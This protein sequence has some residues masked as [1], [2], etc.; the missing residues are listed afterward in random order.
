MQAAQGPSELEGDEEAVGPRRRSAGEVEE[1]V[2]GAVG[3]VFGDDD[4]A[5]AGDAEEVDGA[6]I[7]RDGGEDESFV[8]ER[9]V[10]SKVL[11]GQGLLLH[12][13]VAAVV[14]DASVYAAVAAFSDQPPRREA[15]CSIFN[16]LHLKYM[17]FSSFSC[18]SLL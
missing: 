18:S 4:C 3:H 5:V 9:G 10:V 8:F 2:E 1:V 11:E 7:W 13:D 14:E 17:H 15:L 16:F 6:W 12:G